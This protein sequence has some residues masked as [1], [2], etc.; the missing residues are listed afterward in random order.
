MRD[1]VRDS[2]GR[3]V[4]AFRH[5]AA[6]RQAQRKNEDPEHQFQVQVVGYLRFALPP[7]YVWTANAAGVRVSMH[8]AVKMKAAG[9]RRGWP[10]IQILFPSAVTRYIELKA[11]QSLSDE[12][13]AFRA[14]CQ[15]TGR[16]IWAMAR[17]LE[18]VEAALLRW[19]IPV[20]CP[21]AKAN[22]YAG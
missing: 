2:S 18:E 21:L 17:T 1:I 10:D 7:E 15:A 14:A 16:D 3:P 6:Q 4:F 8:V 22:R 11:K 9:V 13:K 5:G 19:R 12:Q 20:L